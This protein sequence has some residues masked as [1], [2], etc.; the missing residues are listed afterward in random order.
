MWDNRKQTEQIST[1]IDNGDVHQNKACIVFFL[2]WAWLYEKPNDDKNFLYHKTFAS[3]KTAPKHLNCQH[4][5]ALYTNDFQSRDCI[6]GFVIDTYKYTQS[7][8]TRITLKMCHVLVKGFTYMVQNLNCLPRL[9]FGSKGSMPIA[10]IYI[11]HNKVTT[12]N[13][14]I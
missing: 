14:I 13:L 7:V 6:T 2:I 1:I 5:L 12:C 8:R 4:S 3:P 9:R 11:H 10:R